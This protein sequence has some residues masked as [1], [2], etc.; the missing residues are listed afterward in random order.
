MCSTA[1]PPAEPPLT[2]VLPNRLLEGLLC[3]IRF[4]CVVSSW[5]RTAPRSQR[6]VSSRRQQ[7]ACNAQCAAIPSAWWM[8]FRPI[9]PFIFQHFITESALCGLCSTDS[10]N[11]INNNG[12][13]TSMTCSDLTLILSRVGVGMWELFIPL[14]SKLNFIK[15]KQ[16]NKFSTLKKF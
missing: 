1:S 12:I 16:K 9:W 14:V 15:R 3:F 2:A 4:H 10:V 13:I 11:N 5:T 8:H 7:L 6:P